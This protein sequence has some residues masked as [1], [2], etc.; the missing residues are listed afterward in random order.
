MRNHHHLALETPQ[1]D[2]VDGMRWLQTTFA[3]R[4]NRFRSERGHLFQGRYQSLVVED[5]A[6]LVRVINYVHLNPMRAGIVTAPNL[7]SYR[8]SSLSQFVR[9][10]RPACLT[11]DVLLPH[12]GL[13]DSA[14]GWSH[15]LALLADVA[16]RPVVHDDQGFARLST[17]WAI[18]TTGWRRAFA[19]EH[20]HLALASG[21][22]RVELREIKEARWRN[23]LETTL[24]ALGKIS[25][26]A[27]LRRHA[28]A[29]H[30]WIAH[31]LNMGSPA[32]VRVYLCR[33]N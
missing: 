12:L 7:V 25:A 33:E 16:A 15:Y 26:A 14:A 8:W 24:Q 10:P 21:I 23:I 11:S 13:E 1:A 29:P 18:G 9:G 32:S 4:F 17:G 30:R 22:A 27:H 31:T 3:T 2:L 19:P 20:S 28:A 5:A 6:A